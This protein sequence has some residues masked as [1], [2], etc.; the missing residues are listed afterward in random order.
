M[1]KSTNA[2]PMLSS[3][4]ATTPAPKS[5]NPVVISIFLR[6]AVLAR[7]GLA[8]TLPNRTGPCPLHCS[9]RFDASNENAARNRALSHRVTSGQVWPARLRN[10]FRCRKAGPCSAES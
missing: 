1:P 4:R 5:H 10:G 8:T 6:F 2:A 9:R 7:H 3:E